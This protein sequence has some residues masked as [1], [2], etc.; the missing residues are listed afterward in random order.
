MRLAVAFIASG[1]ASFLAA[2]SGGPA[3][4]VGGDA[5]PGPSG[6]FAPVVA[7]GPF[8][9]VV[10]TGPF[11]PVAN[12]GPFAP[13][14]DPGP[15]AMKPTLADACATVCARAIGRGCPIDNC[16]ADCIGSA[17]QI[18]EA[19]HAAYAALLL[20]AAEDICNA[21]GDAG[22]QGCDDPMSAYRTCILATVRRQ[23]VGP[24]NYPDASP[25]AGP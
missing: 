11:A 5:G 16:E 9:P 10:A 20:C 3:Q 4:P 17:A 7:T 6:P 13:V 18:A 2:C 22:I 24:G 12:T 1:L 25:Y 14:P 19:C 21:T 8:A 23:Y 15:F